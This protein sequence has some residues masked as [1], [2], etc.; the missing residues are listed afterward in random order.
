[1][2]LLKYFWHS[3]HQRGW[4]WIWYLIWYPQ[5]WPQFYW[6]C[7]TDIWPWALFFNLSKSYY[8]SIF[9]RD[10]YSILNTAIHYAWNKSFFA[11]ARYS[12][13][14]SNIACLQLVSVL[15]LL[16]LISQ[17]DAD[18]VIRIQFISLDVDLSPGNFQVIWSEMWK[19]SCGWKY[20]FS[21]LM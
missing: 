3:I 2:W 15:H 10:R 5:S 18:I 12:F 13:I 17:V 7:E 11:L 21:F 20:F 9:N 4:C 6:Y 8:S 14:R 19:M 16:N 1:M